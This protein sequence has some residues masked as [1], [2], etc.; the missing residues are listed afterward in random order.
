[1]LTLFFRRTASPR[2]TARTNRLVDCNRSLNR[3]AVLALSRPIRFVDG[4]DLKV[5]SPPAQRAGLVGCIGMSVDNLREP[6][7]V[8]LKQ[9]RAS[10][11]VPIGV[12]V[13]VR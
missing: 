3:T 1:M 13:M 5:V 2:M 8:P 7:Y 11:F 12:R 10:I 4:S 6:K 9:R